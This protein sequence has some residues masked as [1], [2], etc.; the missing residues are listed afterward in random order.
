MAW[1]SGDA[2]PFE[3][4]RSAP[5]HWH[6]D[7]PLSCSIVELFVRC[8]LRDLVIDAS[9]ERRVGWTLQAVVLSGCWGKFEATGG[10]AAGDSERHG[11]NC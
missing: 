7:R 4:G 1:T 5:L 10:K 9:P 11:W 8:R 2:N 6:P 3:V